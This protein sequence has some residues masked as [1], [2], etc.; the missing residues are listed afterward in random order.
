M[1]QTNNALCFSAGLPAALSFSGGLET[2][3]CCCSSRPTQWEVLQAFVYEKVETP[4][5]GGNSSKIPSNLSLSCSFVCLMVGLHLV[6]SAG[7]DTFS[8]GRAAEYWLSLVLDD[9]S[10]L[11]RPT[12]LYM[13]LRQSWLNLT[14][15]QS[16]LRQ[17]S[18]NAS[19][20][21]GKSRIS[22]NASSSLTVVLL[23]CGEA[24]NTRSAESTAT[25]PLYFLHGTYGKSLAIMPLVLGVA[26]PFPDLSLTGW[27]FLNRG[28]HNHAVGQERP[29]AYTS[30][31][32]T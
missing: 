6:Q 7:N 26:V 29:T 12:Y 32:G 22:S 4:R 5:V 25:V 16:A 18:S 8:K 28:G 9:E 15:L 10:G 14:S 11:D 27:M 21:G 3:F 23:E 13:R 1:T 17:N 31:L 30:C 19:K 2:A 20:S 24:D